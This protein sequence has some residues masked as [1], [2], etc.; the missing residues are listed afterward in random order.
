MKINELRIGDWV[1]D[2]GKPAQITRIDCS[3]NIET[4]ESE[5]TYI[6]LIEPIPL[7]REVFEKNNF[8]SYSHERTPIYGISEGFSFV[9]SQVSDWWQVVVDGLVYRHIKPRYVHEVQHI[10]QDINF[11]KEIVL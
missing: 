9:I 3:G 10:L 1:I 6:D 11:N 2:K 7:S 5:N 4:T 8:L